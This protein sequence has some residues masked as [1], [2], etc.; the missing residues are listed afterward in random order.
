[1]NLKSSSSENITASAL[2][3]LSSWYDHQLVMIY[4]VHITETV[5]AVNIYFEV[6]KN[7]FVSPKNRT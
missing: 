5:G 3:D 2:K 6:M 1:V 7:P 4:R